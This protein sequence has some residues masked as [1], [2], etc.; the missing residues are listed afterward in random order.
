M[1]EAHPNRREH[2]LAEAEQLFAR[3]GI[4]QVTTRQIAQAVGISQPSLYAHFGS[5]DAIAVELCR[6][7]FETL[8]ARLAAADSQGGTAL[9]RLERQSRE[10]VAF[11]LAHEAAYRVAFM[12]DMPGDGSADKQ[13]VIEAG[14]G[15]FGI[16]YA[17][18]V[19]THGPAA[20][21]AAQSAWASL[22]GLVALLL[23]RADFPWVERES[24]IEHHIAGVCRAALA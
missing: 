15:A 5:R 16:L 10:Y 9:E 13:V 24:L 17:L 18:F 4:A 11:G 3:D 7:A 23:A 21:M 1:A 14:V 22:H 2:I 19:E 20:L 8:T 12:M 6:R